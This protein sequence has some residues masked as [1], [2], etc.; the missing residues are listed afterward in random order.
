M[1]RV[2]YF[3]V[4]PKDD[5]LFRRALARTDGDLREGLLK[6]IASIKWRLATDDTPERREELARTERALARIEQRMKK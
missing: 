3:S 5:D 4:M 1:D 6:V 2:H